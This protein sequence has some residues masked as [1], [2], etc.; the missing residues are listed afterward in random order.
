MGTYISMAKTS[1]FKI[2][3]L[4]RVKALLMQEEISFDVINHFFL[5]VVLQMKYPISVPRKAIIRP[6]TQI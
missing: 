2:F 3:L 5:F 4:K 6:S 1:I